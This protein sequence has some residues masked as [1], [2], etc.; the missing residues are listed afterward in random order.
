MPSPSY[1]RSGQ[2]PKENLYVMWLRA[3]ESFG[4]CVGAE[5]EPPGDAMQNLLRLTQDAGLCAEQMQADFSSP[6]MVRL[7]P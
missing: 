3:L 5:D 6:R 4:D 2:N 7:S 1:A